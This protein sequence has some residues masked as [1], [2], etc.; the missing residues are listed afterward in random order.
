MSPSECE[1]EGRGLKLLNLMH[2]L[3][4]K[5]VKTWKKI[6]LLSCGTVKSWAMVLCCVT[7]WKCRGDNVLSEAPFSRVL[8]DFL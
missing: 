3:V 6:G 1:P 2:L 7:L 5:I 4:V 8:W